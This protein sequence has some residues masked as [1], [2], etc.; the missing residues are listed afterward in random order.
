MRIRGHWTLPETELKGQAIIP[1]ILNFM[2]KEGVE[3][4]QHWISLAEENVY[5]YD[6]STVLKID[7]PHQVSV[8]NCQWFTLGEWQRSGSVHIQTVMATLRH[9]GISGDLVVLPT[10]KTQLPSLFLAGL[11]ASS[12]ALSLYR[13]YTSQISEESKI[14]LRLYRGV[15][16]TWKTAFIYAPRKEDRWWVWERDNWRLYSNDNTWR[17]EFH[18]S[19]SPETAISA[20]GEAIRYLNGILDNLGLPSL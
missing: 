15:L 9:Y 10:T 8:E 14:N 6:R 3:I 17:L 4:P 16:T 13:Q 20:H 2:A 12:D 11:P 7:V 18:H 5:R 1:S 19:L